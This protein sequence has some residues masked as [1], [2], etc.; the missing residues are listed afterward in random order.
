MTQKIRIELECDHDIVYPETVEVRFLNK[1]G[2]WELQRFLIA[3]DLS[4]EADHN[5]PE[6]NCLR[7]KRL[8]KKLIDSMEVR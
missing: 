3:L 8:D 4:V 7:L 5:R 6:R 2:E 1:D